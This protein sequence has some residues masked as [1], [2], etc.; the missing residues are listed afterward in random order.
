MARHKDQL[1]HIKHGTQAETRMLSATQAVQQIMD[2]KGF[3]IIELDTM[4][5]AKRS[6]SDVNDFVETLIPMN[7][8]PNALRYGASKQRIEDARE[9]F[10]ANYYHAADNANYIGTKLGIINAYYDWICHSEPARSYSGNYQDRRFSK[11][12]SGNAVNKKLILNA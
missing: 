6:N 3:F 12:M 11:I 1:L 8:D 7:L 4:A 10:I 9:D 2:W 5:M